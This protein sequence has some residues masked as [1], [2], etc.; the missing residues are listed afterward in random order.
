MSLV[1][2][3]TVPPLE[4]SSVFNRVIDLRCFL[5]LSPGSHF[6]NVPTHTLELCFTSAH[7]IPDFADIAHIFV[8]L[9]F[10]LCVADWLCTPIWGD[11]VER[12]D[13]VAVEAEDALALEEVL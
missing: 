9:K 2:S 5:E 6:I 11:A 7:E 8:A 10:A 13:D 4:L 3:A 12:A 1:C